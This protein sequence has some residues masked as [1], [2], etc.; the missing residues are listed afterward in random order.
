MP[1]VV[2]IGITEHRCKELLSLEDAYRELKPNWVEL[3]NSI[4]ARGLRVSSRLA[5]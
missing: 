1:T 2:I 5:T 4:Q 3:L